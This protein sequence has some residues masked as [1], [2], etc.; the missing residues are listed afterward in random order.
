M[1]TSFEVLFTYQ[2]VCDGC[3]ARSDMLLHNLRPGQIPSEVPPPDDW[4]VSEYRVAHYFGPSHTH[5]V[6][7]PACV[8]AGKHRGRPTFTCARCGATELGTGHTTCAR[9]GWTL[10]PQWVDPPTK[11]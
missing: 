10:L 5:D 1:T 6:F 4:R 3:G 2:C 7:C 9:C 8:A 11:P